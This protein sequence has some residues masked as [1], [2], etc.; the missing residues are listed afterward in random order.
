[1]LVWDVVWSALDE[2]GWELG[3]C[4]WEGV[5]FLENYIMRL[6]RVTAAPAA[7][8]WQTNFHGKSHTSNV[9]RRTA[10]LAYLKS[11]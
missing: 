10:V 4:W 9:P 5:F 1:M 6:V 7:A 8:S 2:M 3:K 11:G